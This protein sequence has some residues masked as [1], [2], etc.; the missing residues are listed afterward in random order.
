MTKACRRDLGPARPR[1]GSGSDSC[2]H[3]EPLTIAAAGV[4]LSGV[5][6]GAGSTGVPEE[7][8]RAALFP[9]LDLPDPPVGHPLE[10]ARRDGYALLSFA[11]ATFGSVAVERVSLERLDD[12][13]EDARMFMRERSKKR[14]D[15]MVSEETEPT[16]LA[17]TLEALGMQPC[18]EPPGE[19]RLAAMTM[20]VPPVPGPAQIEVRPPLTFEEFHAA[21]HVSDDAFDLSE[22]DRAASLNSEEAMW[23]LQ[24]SEHSSERTFVALVDREVV[25]QAAVI[26]GAHAGFLVGGST[27]EEMRGRGVYRALVRARWDAAVDRGTPALTVKAGRMSHP[28]LE[29]LGFQVVGWEDWLLDRLD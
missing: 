28:I 15:W 27:R 12:V 8:R 19:P 14:L 3:R 1:S 5:T 21:T 6:V 29:R 23:E 16:G 18:D 20:V 4:R 9:H 17:G 11:G 7:V 13:L 26:F 2:G 25:G 24:C 10:L 22:A